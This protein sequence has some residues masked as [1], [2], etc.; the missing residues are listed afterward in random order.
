M[1]LSMATSNMIVTALKAYAAECRRTAKSP[2]VLSIGLG[3]IWNDKAD[4]AD[5]ALQEFQEQAG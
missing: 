5:K 3:S 2:A 1:E 4:A